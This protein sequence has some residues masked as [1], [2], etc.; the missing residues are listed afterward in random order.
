[1]TDTVRQNDEILIAV[2]HL[3]LL[4]QL[5][6]EACAEKA[7][8]GASSAM[9]NQYRIADDAGCIGNRCAD[10]PVVQLEFWN[11]FAARETEILNYIVALNGRRIRGGDDGYGGDRDQEEQNNDLHFHDI[12]PEVLA[13][14]IQ[15]GK[16]RFES[17][18]MD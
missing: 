4:E 9:K 11:C 13:P 16:V 2:Q 12:S 3:P 17:M 10:S 5:P 18:E 14:I 6:G 7:R 1:M 15:S 8:T